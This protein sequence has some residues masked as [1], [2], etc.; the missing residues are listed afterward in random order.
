MAQ[1]NHLKKIGIWIVLLVIIIGGSTLLFSMVKGSST[2]TKLSK[3]VLSSTTTLPTK[4]LIS[5]NGY[6]APQTF[7]NCGEAALS[8]E[9]SFFNVNVSQEELASILRPDNNTTGK[10]DDKSTPP[11]EIAAQAETYGLIAYFRPGGSVGKLKQLIAAGF[12]VLV[13][14]LYLPT[15]DYAHYRV[16]KGYDDTKG[17]FIDEDGI[18][19]ENFPISYTDFMNLWKPFDDEYIVLTPPD[20]KAEVEAIL[21]SAAD[22]TTAWQNAAS[23]IPS[24][25]IDSIDQF[26][27]SVALY[28]TGDYQGSVNAFEKAEPTLSEHALWYQ[29]EPIESYYELGEYDKVFSLANSIIDNGNPA[30]PELYVVEGESYLKQGNTTAAKTAFETALQYN[31]NLKSAEEGLKETLSLKN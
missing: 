10:N 17:V 1:Q 21:G 26:N 28:Y 24:S 25:S 23:A 15:E 22:T 12:P 13:R 31:K 20:K 11:D 4:A 5:D 19:G 2:E 9:L 14:S 18:Q 16:I 27:L 8:M 7:N 29:I 30:Y 3:T 6:Y